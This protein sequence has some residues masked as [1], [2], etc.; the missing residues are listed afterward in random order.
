MKKI[1]RLTEN[2]LMRIVKRIIKEESTNIKLPKVGDRLRISNPKNFNQ[3]YTGEVVKIINNYTIY[4]K[5][6]QKCAEYIWET[7]GINMESEGYGFHITDPNFEQ[8]FKVKP[9]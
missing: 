9:C 3:S 2:D 5:N 1:V 7:E 8:K 6:G 4:L